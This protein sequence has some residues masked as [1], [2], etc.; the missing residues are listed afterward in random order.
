MAQSV[1]ITELNLPQLEMLKN[2]LD[3]VGMGPRDTALP[4]HIPPHHAYSLARLHSSPAGEASL[5][6]RN[7]HAVPG[8]AP[9]PAVPPSPAS[10]HTDP[11]S[12]P[13]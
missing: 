12:H 9:S 7:R 4:R 13:L 6:R 10:P 3:Q 11:Y 1:N 8:P 5:P 2:Q